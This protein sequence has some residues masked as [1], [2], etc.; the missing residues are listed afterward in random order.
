MKWPINGEVLPDYRSSDEVKDRDGRW[1]YCWR[2]WWESLFRCRTQSSQVDHFLHDQETLASPCSTEP[3]EGR[4][5]IMLDIGLPPFV[6]ENIIW[7]T[8]GLTLSQPAGGTPKVRS[9]SGWS[10]SML[11]QKCF[12]KYVLGNALIARFEAVSG[13]HFYN[14]F[15]RLVIFLAHLPGSSWHTLKKK[16]VWVNIVKRDNAIP[17][18]VNLSLFLVKLCVYKWTNSDCWN[19][20][21]FDITRRVCLGQGIKC[22]KYGTFCIIQ[23]GC[24]PT[25]VGYLTRCTFC[26]C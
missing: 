25:L 2:T 3:P 8:W 14:I 16:K 22:L 17:F 9:V 5:E 26:L 15:I 24:N 18:C 4:E 1:C 23:D 20:G 11:H 7:Y 12:E 21:A 19:Y 13:I 10:G 6:G